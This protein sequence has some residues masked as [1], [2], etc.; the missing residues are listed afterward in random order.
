MLY[1][2]DKVGLEKFLLYFKFDTKFDVS[3]AESL[4]KKRRSVLNKSKFGLSLHF[5]NVEF[6]VSEDNLN[7]ESV[8][9]E[10]LKNFAFFGLF[11]HIVPE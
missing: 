4:T 3:I 9:A 8:I 5:L 2:D 7:S 10:Q 1:I 6:A 11:F